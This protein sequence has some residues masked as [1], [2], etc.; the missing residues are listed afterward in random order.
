MISDLVDLVE[1]FKVKLSLWMRQLDSNDFQHFATLQKVEVPDENVPSY[2]ENLQSLLHEFEKRFPNMRDTVEMKLF[3]NPFTTDA[4][5]AD[6]QGPLQLELID[7]HTDTRAKNVFVL[8][9]HCDPLTF[10]KYLAEA[11]STERK[12]QGLIR[13]SLKLVCMFGS[14]YVI[15]QTFSVMNINKSKC[16]SNL[17]DCSLS[18]ILRVHTASDLVPRLEKLCKITNE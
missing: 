3:T 6:L 9:A 16:R 15:E 7:L 14:T 2:V 5:S 17:S 8:N 4:M 1:S 11:D 12:Y 10:W 13:N 18:N